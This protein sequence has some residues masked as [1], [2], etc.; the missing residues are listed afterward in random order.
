MKRFVPD[1]MLEVP[2]WFELLIFPIL[3]TSIFIFYILYKNV[4]D[5]VE[6][7]NAFVNNW[8]FLLLCIGIYSFFILFKLYKT[9]TIV[10][11]IEITDEN[12][13]IFKY[14][15][16][17]LIKKT[18]EIDFNE[19]S[20]KYYESIGFNYT[21]FRTYKS[22]DGGYVDYLSVKIYKNNKKIIKLISLNGWKQVIIDEII[23]EFQ[24]ISPTKKS[25]IHI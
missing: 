12:K 1:K 22:V 8:R 2:R 9:I 20:F 6:Q 15:K 19:F 24:K 11:E 4:T 3:W 7:N 10:D 18:V 16:F 14:S 5:S 17:Y 21:L 23:E 13:I 25:K